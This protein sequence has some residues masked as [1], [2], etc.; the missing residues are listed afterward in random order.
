MSMYDKY[1]GK[2][3]KNVYAKH[4]DFDHI[5]DRFY[6]THPRHVYAAAVVECQNCLQNMNV[7]ILNIFACPMFNREI[8]HVLV[9]VCEFR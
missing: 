3:V 2:N 6:S 1:P 8:V 9:R 4:E 7:D 5:V